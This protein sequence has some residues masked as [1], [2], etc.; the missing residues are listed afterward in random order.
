VA[1]VP[2]PESHFRLIAAEL[3]RAIEAGEYP[4][5]SLLPPEPELGELFGVSRATIN[6]AVRI[7][8]AEGL[9]WIDRGNGTRIRRLPLIHRNAMAR[10]M[11]EARE[12]AGA[13]GA[14]DAEI[15]ALGHEPRTDTSVSVVQPPAEVAAVLGVP[16]DQDSVVRRMRL[17]YADDVPVQIAPSYFPAE[18]VRGTAIE[19]VDSGPGGV[20]SRFA[21]LGL[22]QVRITESVRARAATDEEREFLQLDDAQPVVEIFHTG[23]T[24][25]GRAVEVAVH[26]VPASGW[27]LDYEWPVS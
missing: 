2:K 20:I 23:W 19:Q 21:E 17:M 11:T 6:N 5:G 16:A 7:L 26:A 25:E 15:R 18:L 3:R 9:V 4:A 10:Y 12:Q 24:A 8:R 1:R 13:R 22:A 14:F 27:V